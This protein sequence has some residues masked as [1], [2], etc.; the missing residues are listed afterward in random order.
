MPIVQGVNNQRLALQTGIG[1][2]L[3]TPGVWGMEA[4]QAVWFRDPR[5]S[6]TSV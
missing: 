4:G 6:P 2:S 3:I 1:C 5:E